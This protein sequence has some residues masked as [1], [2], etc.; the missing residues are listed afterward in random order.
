MKHILN[1]NPL[2]ERLTVSI[3]GME[4]LVDSGA[5]ISVSLVPASMLSLVFELRHLE[6]SYINGFG[7]KCTFC[8]KCDNEKND[9]KCWGDIYV[10][11]TFKVD[12][13]V[14]NNIPF[15]FPDD[16]NVVKSHKFVLAG[17]IFP[18]TILIEKEKGR[19][20]VWT[21]EQ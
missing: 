8:E 10:I 18:D 17:N 3:N 5:C 20:T 9:G 19:M 6:R 15:F 11:K 14:F 12:S 1:L 16:Q 4:A 2:F 21:K 13:M 7:G